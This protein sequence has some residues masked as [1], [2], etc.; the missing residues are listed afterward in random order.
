MSISGAARA[1]PLH[2][3]VSDNE[4]LVREIRNEF[5]ELQLLSGLADKRR[6]FDSD[7]DSS[8]VAVVVRPHDDST[9]PA[10]ILQ[11]IEDE[12]PVAVLQAILVRGTPL[13]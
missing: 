13:G 3:A 1:A 9:R 10:S 5:A 7:T 12:E 4:R 6:A 8:G 2:R 11:L